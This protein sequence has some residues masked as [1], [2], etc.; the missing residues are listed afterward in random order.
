MD[1]S[2]M[3]RLGLVAALGGAP[4]AQ[5]DDPPELPAELDKY[6]V[7]L[8]R[9]PFHESV[10]D[11]LVHVAIEGG[12]RDELE[13]HLEARLEADA[14]DETSRIVL[15][16]LRAHADEERSALRL[17]ADAA[18]DAPSLMRLRGELHLDLGEHALGIR[19]LEEAIE[20]CEDPLLAIELHERI[21]RASIRVR[22][23]ER[24]AAAFRAM[25]EVQPASLSL[26]LEVAALLEEHALDAAALEELGV[27]LELADGA[28]ESSVRVLVATGRL[29]ERGGRIEAALDAYASANEWMGPGHWQREELFERRLAIHRGAASLDELVAHYRAEAEGRGADPDAR[30]FLARALLANDEREAAAEVYVAATRDFPDEQRIGR[31]AAQ[32]L[33]SL[34]RVDEAI[35][36]YQRLAE[37]HPERVELLVEAGTLLSVLGRDEAAA[38]QWERAIGARPG[39]LELRMR[40]AAL[41]AEAG[42]RGR[43]EHLL[44]EALEL[45]PGD[46]RAIAALETLWGGPEFARTRT[47]QL[48]EASTARAVERGDEFALEEIAHAWVDRDEPRRAIRVLEEALEIARD[49]DGVAHSLAVLYEQEGLGLRAADLWTERLPACRS[50]VEREDL[51]QRIVGAYQRE[52]RLRLLGDSLERRTAEGSAPFELRLLWARALGL[53]GRLDEAEAVLSAGAEDG[54]WFED[55]LRSRAWIDE[56]RGDFAAA[57]DR[58]QELLER[59]PRD[60]QS[61]LP[62]LARLYGR[63]SDDAALAAVHDQMLEL[64]PNSRTL[65][66][67]I[68]REAKRMR[69]LPRAAELLGRALELQP[70]DDE[71][72]LELVDI[73]L[74]QEAPLAALDQVGVLVRSR[75]AAV[76]EE[77]LLVFEQRVLGAMDVEELVQVL[78]VDLETEPD[79]IETGALLGIAS[80]RIHDYVGAQEVNERLLVRYPREPILLDVHERL[81]GLTPR[82]VRGRVADLARGR[83]DVE[84]T[85]EL[86]ALLLSQGQGHRARSLLDELDDPALAANLC[87]VCGEPREAEHILRAALRASPDDTSLHMRVAVAQLAGGRLGPATNSVEDLV[88]RTGGSWAMLLLHTDLLMERHYRQAARDNGE[89]LFAQLDES[90]ARLGIHPDGRAL[91]ERRIR[92]LEEL[93]DRHDLA[94]DF[95][96]IGGEVLESNPGDLLLLEA[97]IDR[98]DDHQ[99]RRA[100]DLIEAARAQDTPRGWT[101]SAR[102]EL[103]TRLEAR[104]ERRA[105]RAG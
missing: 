9:D 65:L 26:R 45:A 74:R 40:V 21:G 102:R 82:N 10:F 3:A 88:E 17:L 35:D 68:A 52:D 8:E 44:R 2:W 67:E 29:H 38:M 70:D 97:V 96:A 59:N 100:R 5:A 63:T 25:A 12:L 66:L 32:L 62:A 56:Q 24:A 39:D 20:H 91:H 55:V 105:S 79:R 19:A 87:L 23:R 11:R 57:A 72:R 37:R 76:R 80:L 7:Y 69:D 15:A 4:S 43:A 89:R 41:L 1:R 98:M 46:L 83:G 71:S 95:V 6:L 34:G 48:L 73:L 78:R 84:E 77:A 86:A 51:I 27:A 49:R 36:V 33:A 94:R 61:F 16:R 85:L 92:E 14:T 60:A 90:R 50:A 30:L 103:L 64:S 104:F 54:R 13:R 93:F 47:A 42:A 31:E 101:R 75:D 53:D 81:R 99:V 58:W 22:E 28:P 18:S